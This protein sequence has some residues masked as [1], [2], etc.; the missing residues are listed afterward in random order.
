MRSRN[1]PAAIRQPRTSAAV[2]PAAIRAAA[3]RAAC[4]ARLCVSRPLWRPVSAPRGTLFPIN[5]SRGLRR[6]ALT[7]SPQFAAQNAAAKGSCE[8]WPTG[9]DDL[10]GALRL[11]SRRRGGDRPGDHL[12]RGLARAGARRKIS[13]RR[14]GAARQGTG[15]RCASAIGS[16]GTPGSVRPALRADRLHA[17]CRKR[18][19]GAGHRQPH[20]KGP[21]PARRLARGAFGKGAAANA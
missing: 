4:A 19:H 18:A 6:R 12:G 2:H 16:V 20:A 9:L 14:E 13:A 5:A 7:E 21:A 8:R 11:R 17:R 15:R 10:A 3:V 1:M